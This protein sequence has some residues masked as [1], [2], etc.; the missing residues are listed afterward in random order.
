VEGVIAMAP[1]GNHGFGYDPIFFV[2]EFQMTMAELDPAI[3][4]RISH[5]ARACED[6]GPKLASLLQSVRSLKDL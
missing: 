3:K 2:P 1:A 5:R 4:N 6:I